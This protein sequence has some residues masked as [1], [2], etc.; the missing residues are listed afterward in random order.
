[1]R[2]SRRARLVYDRALDWIDRSPAPI[3]YAGRDPGG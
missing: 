2:L 1:M 3:H